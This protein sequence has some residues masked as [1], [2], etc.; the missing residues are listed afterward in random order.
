MTPQSCPD[1]GAANAA[2]A[3]FCESCGK[4]LPDKQSNDDRGFSDAVER[5]TVDR[6]VNPPEDAKDP[7]N[8]E[9]L[10]SKVLSKLNQSG[11]TSGS[12][13]HRVLVL[14]MTLFLFSVAGLFRFG[15]AEL[16]IIVVV[17]L[18]HESGHY[19][20]MR[21]FDYQNV[22]MFF[23]PF[24]GA[25]VSGHK[26]G[27]PAFKEAIVILLGPL[28]GIAIGIVLSIVAMQRSDKLLLEASQMFVFL[29]AF[30][31]L[32]FLPLDGGRLLHLV[33]FSRQRHIEAV[34]QLMAG[35]ALALMGWSIGAWLLSVATYCGHSE[36][37]K[38]LREHGAK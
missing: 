21:L 30:N 37:A 26:T 34:F 10:V 19:L 13:V 4:A 17:L 32:P 31:L 35:G 1:C 15:L 6:E 28:P 14:G 20:G 5:V 29:N 7:A 12:W 33:L 38:L 16:F 18:V 2:D 27:I 11:T 3:A 36:I 24:F 9:P 22:R 25:A 23:I 8:V